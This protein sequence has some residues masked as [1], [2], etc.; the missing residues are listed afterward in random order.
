MNL[1]ATILIILIF[2]GMLTLIYVAGKT[3]EALENY[4][5]HTAQ[6]KKK[7]DS[8][9]ANGRNG[10]RCYGRRTFH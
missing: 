6:R 7:G 8:P 4:I 3:L 1:A 5:K 9:L 2:A 10:G